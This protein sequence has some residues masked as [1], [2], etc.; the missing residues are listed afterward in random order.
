MKDK[1]I[2]NIS[3]AARNVLQIDLIRAI[4]LISEITANDINEYKKNIFINEFDEETLTRWE[5]FMEL[6]KEPNWSLQDRRDRIIYTLLSKE[7]FTP[8][9]LKEQAKI[10]TNGEIDVIEHYNN[11]SFTVKF[12]SIVGLPP[13]MDNFKRFIELN[14]PAHLNYDFELRYNTHG[15]LAEHKLTHEKL[16]RYTHQQIYDTRIFND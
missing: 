8:E 12:L 13:N 6:S 10:F 7:I 2:Y 3:N 4:E 1:I 5:T 14:K 16:K 15:Q 11:Y 9:V